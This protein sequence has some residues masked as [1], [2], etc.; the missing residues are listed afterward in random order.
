MA[1]EWKDGGFCQKLKTCASY[2]CAMNSAG[3]NKG[4]GTVCT[5]AGANKCDDETCCTPPTCTNKKDWKTEFDLA[6]ATDVK[7]PPDSCQ[8]G[9]AIC[10]PDKP[11]CISNQ[12]CF[13]YPSCVGNSA[14]ATLCTCGKL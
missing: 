13:E 3:T 2:N 14:E 10:K 12:E 1:C 6:T 5:D 8:C 7:K 11:Y 4:S 9:T